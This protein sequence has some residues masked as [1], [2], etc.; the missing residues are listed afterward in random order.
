M[1]ERPPPFSA[2][3][4]VEAASRHRS[5]TWAA[6]EL[7]ITH[8]AVSQS[9]RRL[10]ADLG[11]TLFE[12]KGGAMEPSEA[13]LRLAESYF[14]AAQSLDRTLKEITGAPKEGVLAVA[15]PADFGRLWFSGKLARLTEA[16]PDLRIEV[17]T[18][19]AGAQDR[20]SDVEIEF[21]ATE[22]RAADDVVSDVASF[23]VCSPEFLG[24]KE[25][26]RP[27]EVL[28]NP[29]ISGGGLAWEGW[30]THFQVPPKAP[31]HLFDDAAMALDAAAQGAGV[32]L[33]HL[34][35]AEGHLDAGRLVAVPLEAPT[36]RSIR[37]SANTSPGKADLVARF[38]M[39][40]RLE[41]GRSL[42]LH[43][44]RPPALA[45]RT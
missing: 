14:E 30:A 18:L 10:E 39:W 19:S 37:L 7:Q 40:L 15:M 35:A 27:Q 8:S 32:A 2:L 28:R 22:G 25:F 16:V 4:A 31:T 41:V 12:R 43:A 23:P 21:S 13:A 3:R 17:R 38:S 20:Q 1:T 34:F 9:I 33:T 11:T 45:T 29:L 36:G 44:A 6:K 42:A 24:R 5:F 26:S